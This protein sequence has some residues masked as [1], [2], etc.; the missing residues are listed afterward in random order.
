MRSFQLDATAPAMTTI[1]TITEMIRTGLSIASANRGHS[2][3]TSMPSA[4]GTSTIANTSS[5]FAHCMPS[6]PSNGSK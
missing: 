1:S 5:V 3:R 6:S 2:R 4:T